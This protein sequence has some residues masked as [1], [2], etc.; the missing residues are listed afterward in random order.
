MKPPGFD[1][2]YGSCT[3]RQKTFPART[4]LGTPKDYWADRLT[5]I[6]PKMA[7][8]SYRRAHSKPKIKFYSI[9]KGEVE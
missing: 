8:L 7:L 2:P 6:F 9:Q 1:S 5:M 3:E 4:T